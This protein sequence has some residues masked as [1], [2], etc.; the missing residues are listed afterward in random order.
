MDEK[1]LSQVDLA[2]LVGV[3]T[4]TVWG[5]INESMPQRRT[6]HVLCM[7]LN[8]SRQWL[9]DGDGERRSF[10]DS[11]RSADVKL[12]FLETFESVDL[13]AARND[14]QEQAYKRMASDLRA[15]ADSFEKRRMRAAAKTVRKLALQYEAI[16][17]YGE[18]RGEVK[19]KAQAL[20][21]WYKTRPKK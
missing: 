16:D 21:R 8:V 3:S 1:A 15:V 9:I 11:G 4:A 17:P 20:A 19:K 18:T 14:A 2:S 7:R 5:W 12:A 10:E 6:A 13:I